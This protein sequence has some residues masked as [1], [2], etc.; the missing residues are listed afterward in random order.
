MI[1]CRPQLFCEATFSSREPC[2]YPVEKV[3]PFRSIALTQR[4]KHSL[5]KKKKKGIFCPTHKLVIEYYSI[6]SCEFRFIPFVNILLSKGAEI[7]TSHENMHNITKSYQVIVVPFFSAF[8]QHQNLLT[9]NL[10]TLETWHYLP[11]PP[12]Y[13]PEP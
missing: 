1:S 8:C 12:L 5:K 3:G 7:L 2:N 9:Q 11:S 4:A 13:L 10:P 6:K